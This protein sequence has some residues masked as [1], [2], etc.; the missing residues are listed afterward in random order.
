MQKIQYLLLIFQLQTLTDAT[1]VLNIEGTNYTYTIPSGMTSFP[2][3]YVTQDSDVYIDPDTVTATIVSLTGGGFD[4]VTINNPTVTISVSD[5]IDTTEAVLTS[6]GDGDED[7]GSVTYTITVPQDTP[8]QGDQ[9]FTITLSNG[10][11]QTITVP[12]GQSSG[13]I[14][15]A[16]GDQVTNSTIDLD[17]Y[18]DSDVYS[19]ADFVLDVTNVAVVGNGGNYEDL[20]VTDNS[21]DVTIEDTIDTTTVSITGVDV[22][23]DETLTTFTVKLSNPTDENSP[24]TVTVDVGGVDYQVVIPANSD[25]ATFTVPLKTVIFI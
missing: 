15:L 5:T 1:L 24:A 8:P 20:I 25:T 18:P 14:T 4:N 11:T 13:S 19:E 22:N 12:A 17:G 10:Q 6:V 3:E 23:E 21:S 2:V 7:N 9:D 16:W